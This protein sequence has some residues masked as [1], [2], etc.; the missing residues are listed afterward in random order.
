L[1]KLENR[2]EDMLP[3]G[4]MNRRERG[5]L[6]HIVYKERTMLPP[7]TKTAFITGYRFLCHRV[8]RFPTH[9][10]WAMHQSI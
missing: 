4:R 5:T 8:R 10:N 1:P 2:G 7:G 6:G 3:I 9:R